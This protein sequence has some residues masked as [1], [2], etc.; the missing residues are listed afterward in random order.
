[1]SEGYYNWRTKEYEPWTPD[2]ILNEADAEVGSGCCDDSY[3]RLR[4]IM[5]MAPELLAALEAIAEF[6]P[7]TSASEGG[8]AK[9]SANVRAADMVR[10]AIAKARG[11]K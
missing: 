2:H 7:N 11:A 6:I 9:H 3:Q 4:L 10:A 1:M 8:A 5:L